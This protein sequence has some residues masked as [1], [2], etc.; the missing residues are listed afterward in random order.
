MFTINFQK[1]TLKNAAINLLCKL[2]ILV[3]L[4]DTFI[5]SI[6]TFTKNNVLIDLLLKSKS[7]VIVDKFSFWQIIEIKIASKNC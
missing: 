6:W 7:K 4:N 3:T 2:L 5:E 1:L